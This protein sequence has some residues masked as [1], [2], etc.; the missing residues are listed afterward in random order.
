MNLSLT[1]SEADVDEL[2][3]VL[4][5]EREEAGSNKLLIDAFWRQR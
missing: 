1:P 2:V 3:I 5:T 4:T